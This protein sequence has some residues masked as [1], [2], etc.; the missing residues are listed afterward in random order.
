MARNWAELAQ[1][2]DKKIHVT[3]GQQ[4]V[5]DIEL[6]RFQILK[7]A[8]EMK[9]LFYLH[10]HSMYC[11]WSINSSRLPPMPGHDMNA[12]HQGFIVLQTVLRK[13]DQFSRP[14]LEWCAIFPH[15]QFNSSRPS[16]VAVVTRFL[17]SLPHNWSALDQQ[18]VKRHYPFL[19][20]ELLGKLHC[21]SLVMQGILF[22]ACRRRLCLV[23]G[24]ELGN[25][26]QSYFVQDQKQHLN[27]RGE[28]RSVNTTDDLI[29]HHNQDLI[30]R[31]RQ[32]VERAKNG[33]H[34]HTVWE[35]QQAQ[36]Q[37]VQQQ[38]A[39]QQ[40]QQQ[41]SYDP[42]G[43]ANTT[44]DTVTSQAAHNHAQ[45]TANHVAMAMAN[46]A[47]TP[48]FNPSTPV[49]QSPN[50]SLPWL[51]QTSN[52]H[53]VAVSPTTAH[54][55]FTA[56]ASGRPV[57]VIPS[58]YVFQSSTAMPN[59]A[60]VAMMR[61][62]INQ[63]FQP[64][65]LSSPR[66]YHANLTPQARG[67]QSQWHIQQQYMHPGHMQPQQWSQAVN[68]P[69]VPDP[70]GPQMQC[71]GHTQA[72]NT[73]YA[74]Q[75][76]GRQPSYLIS[77]T[78]SPV[79]QQ[80]VSHQVPSVAFNNNS[81]GGPHTTS[82]IPRPGQIIDLGQYPHSHQERKSLLMAI[83]QAQ[84]R[85]PERTRRFDCAEERHYQSVQSFAVAP[86]RLVYL[87]Q[88]DIAISSE[89]YSRLCKRKELPSLDGKPMSTTV[90]EYTS[91]S[92]RLRARCCRLQP[93]NSS[94]E[95]DWVT[96]ESIWPEHIY[97]RFN[98]KSITIRR[99]TH[100][101]KDL[102][103][104]LTDFVQSGINKFQV[105]T[106]SKGPSA[107][108]KRGNLFYM[109][110]E[111]VETVSH[112]DILKSVQ[113]KGRIDREVTLDKIRSRVKSFPDEDGVTIIDRTGDTTQDLSIDLTDPF[114][115]KIFEVP[116][117][118]V[119]CTHMECF[120]LETW[121]TTR[122]T[123]QQIKCGHRDV[124]TCPKRAEPSEPDKWKCPICFGDARPGSLRVD[125]FLE[126]VRKQL[127]SENKLDTK[128]ILVA[129]DGT[130]RPVVEPADD[131]DDSDVDGPV[132]RKTGTTPRDGS[133]N[134]ASIER[135]PVE[136]IELD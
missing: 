74:P 58:N 112:S 9:D 63:Q 136:I 10:L 115:A 39:Q 36:Q 110:V 51:Q 82:L 77:Q 45:Y 81:R 50:Q 37:Q 72:F 78:R 127:Q 25:Q 87:H 113:S 2:V 79:V 48:S 91:G 67:Y 4:M 7:E 40:I 54:D 125:T 49:M 41:Q 34:Q 114:S 121:L 92:L 95:S 23:D 111:I 16:E 73:Y 42:N 8:C 134:S 19:V 90:R 61:M 105:A 86:F 119:S 35:S 117:R 88:L 3:T 128:S 129:A 66:Q 104:E 76:A 89:Q 65:V 15:P 108:D 126:D 6:P 97:I 43:L 18:S 47:R 24:T 98:D 101:G 69:F 21:F 120:D 57:R 1:A 26:A 31:Y 5:N 46:Q 85:S 68:G 118:G 93:H 130:W 102:P 56:Q 53:S 80:Q 116:A 100:N 60:D 106:S 55:Q 14:N 27:E 109:A 17:A 32:L 103:V 33:Q 64:Q 12:I 135:A 20:D 28:F 70:Y 59:S 124:C 96:K 83:H 123:K 22:R 52:S 133:R 84:T 30:T 11:A 122:P 75:T 99:S 44:P 94:E 107:T 131:N 13:N 132:P 29:E 62:A 38:L 71:S